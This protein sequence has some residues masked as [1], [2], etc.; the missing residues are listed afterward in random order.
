MPKDPVLDDF[1]NLLAAHPSRPLVVSPMRAA[2]AATVDRAALGIAARLPVVSGRLVALAVP[3]GPAFLAGWIALRRAGAVPLL[4][5]AAMPPAARRT[6]AEALGACGVLAAGDGWATGES[7]EWTSCAGADVALPDGTALV[8]LT[9]GSTGTPRGIAVSADAVAADDDQ[10][11]PTMG[12][13][14]VERAL[15]AVALSHSYGFS[16]LALPALRRGVTLVVPDS[17]GPLSPLHAARDCGA[18]FFPSV[19]AW[20]AAL[21]RLAEPPAWPEQLRH[22]ISAGAPLSADTATRFERRLGVPVHVFYGSSECGGITF[23]RRGD[24]ASR[25]T[26][27]TPVEGVTITLD[28]LGRPVVRSRAVA[29]G[30]LPSPDPRLSGGAFTASD[31]AEWHGGELRLRGR[32]D[33]LVIVRGKNVDPREVEDVVRR[34]PGVEDVAVLGLNGERADPLLRAVIACAPQALSYD[35]VTRHCREHLA[36]H[37][38]PRSI[39]FVASC[40]ALRAASST[41]RLCRGLRLRRWLACS[42]HDGEGG[43]ERLDQGNVTAKGRALPRLAGRNAVG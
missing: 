23:D 37:K 33:D 25:G 1:E 27:G 28:D 35:T 14:G 3:N 5:D 19:P 4:C 10:L 7:C 13:A 17:D 40:H 15:A 22:V 2:D 11:V 12:L 20:L 24:A 31:L 43:E 42:G 21:A 8:K 30:A 18:T 6:M 16:S 39:V 32:A 36:D 34:L 41:A 29:L 26:V 38:V 9:S